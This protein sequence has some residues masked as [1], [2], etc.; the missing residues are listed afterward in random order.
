[1]SSLQ[2]LALSIWS[3]TRCRQWCMFQ[4]V[5]QLPYLKAPKD[6]SILSIQKRKKKWHPAIAKTFIINAN[7][8]NN[9][10]KKSPTHS[11]TTNTHKSLPLFSSPHQLQLFFTTSPANHIFINY[12]NWYWRLIVTK[13]STYMIFFFPAN[14]ITFK[15]KMNEAALWQN[16]SM[17]RIRQSMH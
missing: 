14:L 10:K 13:Q 7:N 17:R 2:I 4:Y 6:P 15:R 16:E 11:D 5:S 1:M 3:S 12:S 8:S 9:E